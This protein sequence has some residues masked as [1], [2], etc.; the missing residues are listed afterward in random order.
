MSPRLLCW[1]MVSPTS[2]HTRAVLVNNTWG[3][4]CHHLLFM[5]P[6]H[7][8]GWFLG[9]RTTPKHRH[10]QWSPHHHSLIYLVLLPFYLVDDAIARPSYGETAPSC[11]RRP[12]H[13]MGQGPDGLDVSFVSER[14]RSTA[15]AAFPHP[16][17]LVASLFLQN[18][19]TD[20][21]TK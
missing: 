8:P 21:R 4:Y 15:H 5:A 6:T 3:R 12:H 18:T 20:G 10:K 9:G 2:L 11:W 17:I 16:L 19:L 13:A 14:V 7:F 1:T